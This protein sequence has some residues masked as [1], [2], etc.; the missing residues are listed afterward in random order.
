MKEYYNELTIMKG[1]GIILV[2]LGH[3]FSFTGF[4]LLSN[5]F[6]NRYLYDS[7]YSFHMPLFFLIAGFLSNK[8][9]NNFSKIF[10]VSKTKRLLIP[11]IFINIIDAIPRHLFI[12]FVN[13]KSNNLERII[14]Y[15]GAATWFV[16]TLF[17]LFLVFPFVEK[18]IIK[19]DKYYLFGVSLLFLN[20]YKIGYS[21]KIFTIDRL[22]Y[23]S[24][25]FYVGYILKKYYKSIVE[26]FF[27]INFKFFTSLILIFLLVSYKYNTGNL[28]RIMIPFLGIVITWMFAIKIRSSNKK[29]VR[30]MTFCGENSLAFYLLEGFYG[31]FYRV[32]LIKVIPIEYNFFL[33]SSLFLLKL[34][35]LYYGVKYIVSKIKIL[36]FLL[37]AKYE[38]KEKKIEKKAII[39]NKA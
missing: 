12:N 27:S 23:M 18:I 5:N 10:Y 17:L 20:I 37:G 1:I 35:S 29:Y 19:R 32:L 4:N 14:L 21:I 16:Y 24:F 28:T 38:S 15:S 31:T 8:L 26:Y 9:E 7:I 13:N 34:F 22:V 2:I 30:F 33:V 3:S 11:Y 36:S 6:L 25:Y 39:I